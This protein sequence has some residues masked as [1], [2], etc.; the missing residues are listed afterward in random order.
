MRATRE[1]PARFLTLPCAEYRYGNR[2]ADPH[3]NARLCDAHAFRERDANH[4]LP[5]LHRT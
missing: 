4:F 2:R 3:R 1:L 5:L